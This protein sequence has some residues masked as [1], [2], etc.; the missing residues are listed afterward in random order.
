[1]SFELLPYSVGL[2]QAYARRHA[3]ARHDF[4]VPI[5]GRVPVDEAVRH[6]LGAD[7]VG[8]SAYVW[9]VELSLAI[10]AAVKRE[11]PETVIVFGGPQVPDRVE[12]FLRANPYVD[13][14]CHGEGEQSFAKLLDAAPTRDWAT[15]PGCSYLDGDDVVTRPRVPRIKQLDEIPSPFLEGEFDALMS[16]QP[17]KQ[18]VAMW[19]TNRGCP[20]SCSFCDWGSATASKVYRFGMERLLSEIEWIADRRIGFVFCCDANF[21]MLKR[22]IEIAEAVVASKE[23]TG[24]PFSFS[25]QNTKNAV[26]RGYKVQTLLNQSLNAHGA[27]ISVQSNNPET[28]RN[29]NRANISSDAFRELQQRFAREGVYTYTDIII[30]LP[31]ESYDMFADGVAKVIADGQHNH[32][33]FHN[34]S[35][36]PNAEMGDPTYQA[37]FGMRMVPQAIRNLHG[38]IE[39]EPEV[40]EFLDLVI[41]TD[42]MPP[43]D[44]RRTKVFAWFVDLCYFD[45]LVQI[46][47]A[48]L[49]AVHGVSCRELIE[50][51]LTA[52]AARHPTLAS[53]HAE[54]QAHARGIQSGGPEYLAVPAW[55]NLLWPA[56]QYVLLKLIDSGRLADLYRE[57]GSVLEEMMRERGLDRGIPFIRDAI[58][59]NEALLK[60]PYETTDRRV[61][62]A[63]RVWEYYLA[64]LRCEDVPVP[65]EE[66]AMYTVDRSST[67][68]DTIDGFCD[69][70]TWCQ[71]KDKRNY[72]YSMRAPQVLRVASR[73]EPTTNSPTVLSS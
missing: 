24:F 60:V 55:G 8:F 10:A 61:V 11:R 64:L 48:A 51:L 16:S 45:R 30:G 25:V 28:L 54:L 46:P 73:R 58:T 4:L 15:V 23:D 38:R 31:G 32:M 53:T 41:A 67:S 7:V 20:F 36:L 47:F 34:C 69:H 21:G 27:T 52:D 42:A 63:H 1:M 19:E 57:V 29:I 17:T 33:Q 37:R 26:E 59:L 62:L 66:L 70:L 13:V 71:S 6:L 22:D 65:S 68:W 39:D 35:V 40:E 56:D 72:L 14:A 2:L 49:G 43:E 3:R 44:W 50:G 18:W 5:H 9:N 12:P